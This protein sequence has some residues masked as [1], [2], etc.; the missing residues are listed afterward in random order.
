MRVPSFAVVATSR[1]SYC[2]VVAP[3]L[4]LESP[5]RYSPFVAVF[6]RFCFIKLIRVGVQHGPVFGYCWT[7]RVLIFWEVGDLQNVVATAI[8]RTFAAPFAV[9]YDRRFGSRLFAVIAFAIAAFIP[10]YTS[11]LFDSIIF[12]LTN[13]QTTV[14][15]LVSVRAALL[16]QIHLASLVVALD[17]EDIAASRSFATQMNA[18]IDGLDLPDH[19]HI[20]REDRDSTCLQALPLAT[21]FFPP[22]AYPPVSLSSLI[23]SLQILLRS[24]LTLTRS[25]VSMPCS[26]PLLPLAP[27]FYSSLPMYPY[28]CS[29]CKLKRYLYRCSSRRLISYLYCFL[30][31][32][33]RR[34]PYRCSNRRSSRFSSSY[35]SP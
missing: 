19:S 15:P 6:C 22:L 23:L 26:M 27:K 12:E 25:P 9:R 13:P 14:A 30:S 34:Y 1:D 7:G 11:A 20:D 8:L 17:A 32:R 31:R 35:S 4:H 5:S 16:K 28:R 10:E 2:T 18:L 3:S 21:R 29:S 24:C 33:S